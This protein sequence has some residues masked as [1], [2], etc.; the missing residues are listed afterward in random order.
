MLMS[1]GTKAMLYCLSCAIAGLN[2][3]SPTA[4]AAPRVSTRRNTR[5]FTN[6]PN[7]RGRKDDCATVR[8]PRT[9]APTSVSET[10]RMCRF[11]KYRT[12]NV[13]AQPMP[14]RKSPPRR[15]L[16]DV[17]GVGPDKLGVVGL[18]RPIGPHLDTHPLDFVV[19]QDA[20]LAD[21]Q[22]ID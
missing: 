20:R 21:L 17:R 2:E 7:L 18:L 16:S 15:L 8:Q 19:G 6:T 11:R 10:E 1:L 13:A 5:I 22:C 4:E 3:V 9:T 12:G 14:R